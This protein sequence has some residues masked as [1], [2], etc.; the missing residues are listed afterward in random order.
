MGRGM[1]WPDG[2]TALACGAL[3]AAVAGAGSRP[4][5]SAAA[6]LPPAVRALQDSLLAPARGALARAEQLGAQRNLPS[7]RTAA[8]ARLADL[9]A[10]IALDPAAARGG[11][12]AADL[13]SAAARGRRLVATARLI[14]GLRRQKHEWEAVALAYERDLAAAARAAGVEPAPDLGGTEL[15]RALL[16]SLGRRRLRCRSLSDSLAAEQRLEGET[17]R[18]ELAVRDSSLAALRRRLSELQ[19]SLWEMELKAGIALADR[20]AVEARLRRQRERAATVRRLADEFAREK[21]E[22]SLTA[23]GAVVLRLPA[24]A[25]AP[26]ETAVTPE[27]DGALERLSLAVVALEGTSVRV[28]GHTDNT[29]RRETNQRL[30]QTRAEAVA[31]ALAERLGW[32]PARVSAVGVGQDR[33]LVANATPAG[34]ARN[35]RIDV[36]VPPPPDLAP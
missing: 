14:D 9:E 11:A 19:Q 34:R 35:R 1:R 3:L 4:G 30:A 32:P 16:D 26:N 2:L 21:G 23:E 8:R 20:A 13:D 31:T 24:L 33:P 6:E 25:F 12:L 7:L 28:E 22:V 10:R 27:M 5:V 36:V 29:G 18:L 17:L 15:A